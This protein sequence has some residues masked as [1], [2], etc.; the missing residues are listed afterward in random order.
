M[1]NQRHAAVVLHE[2]ERHYVRHEAP[3]TMWR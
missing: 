1:I 3:L 2:F